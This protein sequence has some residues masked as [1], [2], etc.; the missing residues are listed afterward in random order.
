M[1]ITEI[2]IRKRNC[3]HKSIPNKSPKD[4]GNS[5]TQSKVFSPGF[6]KKWSGFCLSVFLEGRVDCLL[7]LFCSY[8]IFCMALSWLF[9]VTYIYRIFITRIASVQVSTGHLVTTWKIFTG[10][11]LLSSWIRWIRGK[12]LCGTFPVWQA[13]HETQPLACFSIYFSL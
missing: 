11:C 2:K 9:L 10:N 3:S 6:K 5:A 7:W 8:S 4:L 1:N 13:C 12:R